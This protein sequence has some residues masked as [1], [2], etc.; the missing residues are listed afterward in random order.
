M[1]VAPAHRAKV[2]LSRSPPRT[3][4]GIGSVDLSKHVLRAI[5]KPSFP[6]RHELRRLRRNAELALSGKD[7]SKPAPLVLLQVLFD[8][9]L[10]CVERIHVGFISSKR[11]QIYGGLD[12]EGRRKI[13]R[14]TPVDFLLIRQHLEPLP[15]DYKGLGRWFGAHGEVPGAFCRVEIL[16]AEGLV[17]ARKKRRM[18][19]VREGAAARRARDCIA[20][21]VALRNVPGAGMSRGLY[22]RAN[23]SVLLLHGKE[24]PEPPLRLVEN[25]GDAVRV[26]R[27]RKLSVRE[28]PWLHQIDCA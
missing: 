8:L 2:A 15:F 25:V 1:R 28:V 3:A 6:F 18:S 27:N 22:P 19:G 12:E 24:V 14:L 7:K 20:H 26:L 16:G 13:T 23:A 4:I 17:A 21:R 11:M 5:K 10:L 9:A